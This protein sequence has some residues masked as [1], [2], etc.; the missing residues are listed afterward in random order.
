MIPRR[1]NGPPTTG[2]GGYSCGVAAATVDGPVAVSLRAPPTLDT[3]F[4]VRETATG[5]RVLHGETV[6]ADVERLDSELEL[7]VP[8]PPSYEQARSAE[9]DDVPNHPFPTCFGCGP[10]REPGDGLR[11]F[12]GPVDGTDLFAATWTP[13]A[14]L[15]S[16]DG[17]LTGELVWAALDCPSSWP[18][19]SET[20]DPAIVLGRLA[21]RPI[22]PIR[23]GESH[24]VIS[25]PIELDGRKRHSGVG[26]HSADGE[27]KAVGQAL[28]I[29][30]K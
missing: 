23:I 22:A 8:Q 15:P 27:L 14:S 30:L 7:E 4:H 28:W 12:P 16:S 21:A 5:A 26:I 2:H 25:W 1:F 24:T 13:D 18:V 11:V 10:E 17:A 29:E 19:A 20:N 9:R 3:P 6:V